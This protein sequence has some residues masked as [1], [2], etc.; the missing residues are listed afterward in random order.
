[1]SMRAH[2]KQHVEVLPLRLGH[3]ELGPLQMLLQQHHVSVADSCE[4]S[5]DL[6]LQSPWIHPDHVGAMWVLPCG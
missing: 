2:S 3:K 1:M 6:Q 4:H 5:C